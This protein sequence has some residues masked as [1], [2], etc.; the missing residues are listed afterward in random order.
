MMAAIL[1][2][3]IAAGLCLGGKAVA[4]PW[5]QEEGHGIIIMQ[6]S[7]YTS[8]VT[9]RDDRGRLT[10]E[11]RLNRLDVN[12][13]WEHGLS[14]RWTVGLAPRLSAA[15]LDDRQQKYNSQGLAEAFGFIRYNIHRGSYDSL[16]IQAGIYTPGIAHDTR[17]LRIGEQNASYAVSLSYGVSVPLPAG[18]AA[19]ASAE[20]SYRYRPGAN[21]DEIGIIGTL[22][23]R[24]LPR[25]MLLAQSFSTI[26]VRNNAPGGTDYAIN[27]VQFSVVH[28]LTERHAIALGYMREID[29][30]RVSL[31][32][33][34]IG[35]LWYKY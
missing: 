7:P 29:G 23:F 27:K 9:G 8:S 10:G 25:W 17:S 31:G 20:G 15:W 33:A 24:P 6:L 35:S 12:P 34:I 3:G 30:R 21:A 1:A 16:S 4:G 28:D 5:A 19:F 2:G 22:G 18:M 32:S 13:Y 26:G 14:P 11:G